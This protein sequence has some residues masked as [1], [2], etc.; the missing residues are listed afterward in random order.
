MSA[1][2]LGSL[3]FGISFPAVSEIAQWKFMP[4]AICKQLMEDYT[5]K[6]QPKGKRQAA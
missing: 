5:A 6:V 4:G 2:D 3:P 1:I